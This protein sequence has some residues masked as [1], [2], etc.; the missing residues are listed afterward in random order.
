MKTRA[1]T[2]IELL[3]VIAIIAF[4]TAIVIPALG[5]SRQYARAIGCSSKIKQLVINLKNYELRNDTFPYSFNLKTNTPLPGG[6]AGNRVYDRQGW[7]W[8][9]YITDYSVKKIN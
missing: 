3:I 2:I 8:F 9:N 7:W 6:Y 4:L 5:F 1:F